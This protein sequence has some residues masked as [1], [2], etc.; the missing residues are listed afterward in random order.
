MTRI[1]P[2]IAA[3]P[4]KTEPSSRPF[5]CDAPQAEKVLL[6]GDFNDWNP[7]ATPMARQPDGRWMASLELTHGYHEYLFLVD[8][9]PMLDPNATVRQS[10]PARNRYHSWPSVNHE[11]LKPHVHALHALAKHRARPT[12]H[13]GPRPETKQFK[14]NDTLRTPVSLRLRAMFSPWK[15]TCA[16]FGGAGRMTLAEWRDAEEQ[17]RQKVAHEN[18]KTRQ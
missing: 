7:R 3:P 14:R 10:T 12:N 9:K 6:V 2:C 5:F 8:G 13:R 1:S 11:R 18:R 15:A 16:A 17:L 4:R